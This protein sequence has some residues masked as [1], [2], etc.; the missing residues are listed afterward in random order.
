MS[1]EN[2]Y[3]GFLFAVKVFLQMAERVVWQDRHCTLENDGDP[4]YGNFIATSTTDT[5]FSVA[6]FSRMDFK[7]LT[8]NKNSLYLILEHLPESSN[9]LTVQQLDN[10]II[11]KTRPLNLYKTIFPTKIL[12]PL[13]HQFKF[14]LNTN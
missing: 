6:L 2:N 11:N 13:Y 14:A 8:I 7:L 9:P 12:Y 10:K 5:T 3:Q 4:N 1:I